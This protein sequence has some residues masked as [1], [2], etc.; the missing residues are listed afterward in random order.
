MT[1]LQTIV[2]EGL[3]ELCNLRWQYEQE[4]QEDP[5]AW[6]ALADAFRARAA[7][8]N[9]EKC[10]EKARHCRAIR[11]ER[12]QFGLSAIGDERSEGR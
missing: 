10:L 4:D 1:T 7:F 3:S 2:P 8:A 11:K 12:A 9:M 6:Q 5:G